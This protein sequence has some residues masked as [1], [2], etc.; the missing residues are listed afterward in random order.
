YWYEGD[1]AGDLQVDFSIV[2]D[3]DFLIDKPAFMKALLYKCEAQR[4]SCG[5]C[6]KAPSVFECGWCI[7]SRKCLLRQHC[8][9]A[10]QNWMH[11]GRH[12]VRCSHPRIT[13]IDP[14]TGPRE[15][16][17]RVTIEGE[18]L[19]LQVKEIS[20]IQVAGVR[21][22]P[23]P[24]LYISAERIVCDMA[25]A[26]LPHSPGGPV[27]LCIGVCSAEYR[28]LST[29]TY[30]FVSPSFTRIR[31]LKGP[32]S[33]GTRLT[34]VGRHLDSGSGV[35]VYIHKEECLFVKLKSLFEG[36]VLASRQRRWPQV[37]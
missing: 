12:N 30:S 32:V 27:E 37:Y 18:N 13:K 31:P 34:V 5:Q 15:G 10:E 16:G 11:H 7:E 33:G 28:T 26:L 9:S 4:S 23:V 24:L 36:V 14:L 22:N 29:Q 1:E 19:G 3:G 25:E 35:S 17:T 21:C 8:P 2:W 6:L 20:H